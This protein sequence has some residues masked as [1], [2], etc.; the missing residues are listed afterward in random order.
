MLFY[1]QYHRCIREITSRP[2]CIFCFILCSILLIQWR[3]IRRLYATFVLKIHKRSRFETVPLPCPLFV[4]APLMVIVFNDKSI[5]IPILIMKLLTKTLP[6][7]AQNLNYVLNYRKLLP[8]LVICRQTWANINRG[9]LFLL[10]I[11]QN[12]Q[13][14]CGCN[15]NFITNH[16]EWIDWQNKLPQIGLIWYKETSKAC[17]TFLNQSP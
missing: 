7:T 4:A 15:T 2:V 3:N 10:N 13:W 14:G 17:V 11:S 6:Q 5:V 1:I 16:L 8:N 12:Y 9:S